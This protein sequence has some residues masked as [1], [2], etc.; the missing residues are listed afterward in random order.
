MARNALGLLTQSAQADALPF[1][2]AGV[3]H[4]WRAYWML[5]GLCLYGEQDLARKAADKILAFLNGRPAYSAYSPDGTGLGAPGDAAT[6]AAT[7]EIALQRQEQEAFLL[8]DTKSLAGRFLQVRSLD[9]AFYLKRIG[10]SEI[11]AP[12]ETITL[13]SPSGGPIMSEEAFVVTAGADIHLQ[14]I[15]PWGLDLSEAKTHREIFKGT[16]HAEI[17]LKARVPYLVKILKS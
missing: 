3:F 12:Y 2:E 13:A 4:P 11:K 16:K 8:A 1:V 14:L 15:S 7:L 5:R 10:L 17:I 9:G 6:A